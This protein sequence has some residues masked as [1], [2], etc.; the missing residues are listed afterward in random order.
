M[1][2]APDDQVLVTINSTYFGQRIMATFGYAATVVT[3]VIT[4]DAGVDSLLN[5]FCG[6]ADVAERYYDCC[7]E[8]VIGGPI[9]GQLIRPV[10]F[11]KR[12]HAAFG[13][14]TLTPA[15]DQV[16]NVAAV[17]TRRGNL[18]TRSNISSLH[19]PAPA[20]LDYI[21]SGV[22]TNAYKVFLDL[23]GTQMRAAITASGGDVVWAP[24]IINGPPGGGWTRIV[25]TETQLT[26]RVMRRR[27]VGLGI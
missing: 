23:L 21:Q 25:Q 9:W 26:S 18:A 1:A 17:I 27:T 8:S 16:S 19:V 2:I 22:I 13:D 24:A 14:G 20:D 7:S 4:E 6:G 3:G 12:T 10:R 11:A 5:F 15:S